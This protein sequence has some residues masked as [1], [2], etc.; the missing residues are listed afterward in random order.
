MNYWYQHMVNAL[1][2]NGKGERTQQAYTRSC[3]C[4]LSSTAK[5]PHSTRLRTLALQVMEFIRRFLQHVLPSGFMKVRYYGFLNP[6]CEIALDRVR[7]LIEISYHFNIDLPKAA[8]K[9]SHHITCPSCGGHLKLRS[10][11]LPARILAWSG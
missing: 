7:A 5:P 6:N 2:L 3:A 10:L 4:L 9:P 1:Q 11:L 8:P